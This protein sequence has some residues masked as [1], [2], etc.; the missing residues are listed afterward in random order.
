MSDMPA[1]SRGR[2]R[3]TVLGNASAAPHLDSPAAGFLVDWGDAAILLD[4]GQG[5]VRA[6][7]DVMDPHD[8]AGVVVGHM[9]ADHY[10]DLAGLRYLYPWG[11]RSQNPLPVHL[12]PGGT[13]RLDALASA[14]SERVGFFH[15]PTDAE[16]PLKAGDRVA[17]GQVLGIIDSLS[18]PIPLQPARAGRVEEVLVEDG[19]PVEF[20][21]P[22]FVLRPETG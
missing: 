7:Q 11:E 1:T 19:Q 8:L 15:Y 5:V 2:L 13:I 12:P 3:L 4:V 16:G 10:L 18:V 9:H 17:A 14:I 21:Q 6:L 22:L 20:G